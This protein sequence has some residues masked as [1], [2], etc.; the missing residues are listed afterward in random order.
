MSELMGTLF[1]AVTKNDV[2]ESKSSE[3]GTLLE[4]RLKVYQYGGL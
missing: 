4:K 2:G 1:V 3:F